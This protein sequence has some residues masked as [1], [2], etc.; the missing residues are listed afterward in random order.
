LSDGCSRLNVRTELA[1]L[2]REAVDSAERWELGG[3]AAP[4]RVR[5]MIRWRN[6]LLGIA[7]WLE[8]ADEVGNLG[9]SRVATLVAEVSS[10]SGHGDAFFG[11][12]IWWVADAM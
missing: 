12:L 7:D 5:M 9:L 3:Y 11:E 10:G 4:D 1:R 8:Q 2:L 6:G